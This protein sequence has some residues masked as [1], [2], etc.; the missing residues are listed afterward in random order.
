MVRVWVEDHPTKPLR[1]VVSSFADVASEEPRPDRQTSV[2]SIEEASS[3]VHQWLTELVGNESG[4][5]QHSLGDSRA[6]RKKGR[7]ET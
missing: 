2:T 1:M 4:S 7:L 6:T 3:I 5:A